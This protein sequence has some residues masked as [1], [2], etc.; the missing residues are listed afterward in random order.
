MKDV[1]LLVG[2]GL[3]LISAG[4]ATTPV[5][6]AP[7]GPNPNLHQSTTS[8]G[9]LQVFSSVEEK[10]DEQIEGGDGSPVWHQHTAFAVY[11]LDGKLLKRVAN[12]TGH[13]TESPETVDLPAGRYLVK[14]RAKDYDLVTVPVLIE[15]G[16]TTRVHLDDNWTLP[17]HT[18]RIDLVDMPNGIPVG[19]RAPSANEFG[20][21]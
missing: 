15:R 18:P 10:S 14:A 4:C 17:A 5:A 12:I 2:C 7:V 6:L 9:G 3:I 13:Y 20:I 1:S 11:A 19:W 16:R 8:M 21:R